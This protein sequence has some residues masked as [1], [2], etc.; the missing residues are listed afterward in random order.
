MS[1]LMLILGRIAML[2]LCCTATVNA[3]SVYMAID[4]DA[5]AQSAQMIDTFSRLI[6]GNLNGISFSYL[7]TETAA[8]LNDPDDLVIT[9]GVSGLKRVLAGH[10]TSTV[11]AVLIS[12]SSYYQVLEEFPATQHRVSA[13]FSEPSP[14]R[15]LALVKALYGTNAVVGYLMAES[16]SIADHTILDS[17]SDLQRAASKLG[18]GME[19]VEV[20]PGQN[21]KSAFQLFKKANVLLLLKRRELFSRISLDDMLLHAYDLRSQGVI[22]YSSGVV[23]NGGLAT[24]YSSLEDMAFSVAD[25]VAQFIEGKDFPDPDY[26]RHYSIALNKYVARSLNIR[27][28]QLADVESQIDTMLASIQ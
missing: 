4:D 3:G 11:V 19:V 22:G 25:V 15:Q 12:R 20:K 27:E 6:A 8:G 16:D 5:P 18:I 26:G 1:A 2:L 9:F 17:A 7:S 28:P 10:G 24:T 14:M 21:A 23:Q 13:V